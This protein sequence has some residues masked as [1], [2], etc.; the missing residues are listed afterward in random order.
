MFNPTAVTAA[1]ELCEHT[2]SSSG[3]ALAWSLLISVWW[4]LREVETLE[5][6]VS[7]ATL[8][9]QKLKTQLRTTTGALVVGVFSSAFATVLPVVGSL[10][11]SRNGQICGHSLGKTR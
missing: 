5:L 7:S 4:M 1:T 8:H 6:D 3:P 9:Q 10:Y 2:C 11:L